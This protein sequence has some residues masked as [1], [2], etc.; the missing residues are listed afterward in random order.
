MKEMLETLI[1]GIKMLIP[2]FTL[3]EALEIGAELGMTEPLTD[4]DGSIFTN[5]NGDI[6]SFK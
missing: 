4:I 3:D 5:E 6:F 2:K 1:N